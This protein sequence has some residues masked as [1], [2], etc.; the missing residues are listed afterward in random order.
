MQM[1]ENARHPLAFVELDGPE[2]YDVVGKQHS[3]QH[4]YIELGPLTG[5]DN[6]DPFNL[7]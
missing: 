1:D 3:K 4:T 2:L 7:P 5:Y 6:R